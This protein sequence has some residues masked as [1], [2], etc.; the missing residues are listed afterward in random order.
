MGRVVPNP[1]FKREMGTPPNCS[2]WQEEVGRQAS[3]AIAAYAPEESGY[4]KSHVEAEA[5][6]T[7]ASVRIRAHYPQPDEPYPLW[8]DV[9]TGIYGPAKRYITP[10]VAKA[11][12]WIDGQTGERRFARRVRGVRG[13]HYFRDG[14]L[15]L[16]T[17]VRDY[18]ESGGRGERLG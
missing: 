7:Q 5:H 18:S 13:K 8:Q 10:K 16:F 11:L 4:L 15:T 12:S 14:L 2:R 9:G 6:P 1:N 17:K 3:D